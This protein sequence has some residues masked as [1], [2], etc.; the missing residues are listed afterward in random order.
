MKN[1]LISLL[2]YL[3]LCAILNAQYS[4]IYKGDYFEDT[5]TN[6]P[7]EGIFIALV[8]ANNN[9]TSWIGNEYWADKYRFKIS[10]QG[11]G[12]LKSSGGYNVTAQFNSD[13]G[14][15]LTLDKG[16]T[17]SVTNITKVSYPY[18]PGAASLQEDLIANP[19]FYS[20]NPLE[21]N[22]NGFEQGQISSNLEDQL[23]LL[24]GEWSAKFKV[25]VFDVSGSS[26]K[27]TVTGDLIIIPDSIYFYAKALGE[28]ALIRQDANTN[29]N[30]DIYLTG[31]AYDFD[32]RTLSASA[33]V[34]L[35]G[36]NGTVSYTI[37][38]V[39]SYFD[40]DK[41]G[42]SDYEEINTYSTNP[43]KADSDSDGMSDYA[44]I[45]AASNPNNQSEYPTYMKV[46]VALAKGI[47][48]GGDASVLIDGVSYPL[49]LV[50]GKGT[51]E[52]ALPTGS[53][54][55]VSAS[56]GALT[57]GTAKPV[58]MNKATSLSL[59]LDGDSDEDGLSD[60]QEAR[61]KGDPNNADTDGDGISDGDEVY[62]YRTSV[63]VADSD[64]DGFTD[65]Q[66][67]DLNTNPL[68]S[69]DKPEAYIER[70]VFVNWILTYEVMGDSISEDWDTA[71]V[72]YFLSLAAGDPQRNATI[73][74]KYSLDGSSLQWLI[75]NN[76]RDIDVTSLMRPITVSKPAQLEGE[77][78][79]SVTDDGS[80]Y[81]AEMFS[82]AISAGKTKSLSLVVSG[83]SSFLQVGPN[84]S[85]LDID[86]AISS[87]YKVLGL[88]KDLSMS[89]GPI[90][91]DGTLTMGNE[92]AN[93]LGQTIGPV[94]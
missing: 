23:S 74:L 14:I 72:A 85:G 50:R 83:E 13:G 79:S 12:S 56:L 5:P 28:S 34:A 81:A 55:S 35:S 63:N 59:I 77:V 48:G 41:D 47:S 40:T 60:S 7:D 93:V 6:G 46:K 51:L 57:S 86:L 33:N 38:Q 27:V 18:T 37:D 11:V 42:L 16:A 49:P 1:T 4:G 68:S 69:K 45:E 21:L 91:I 19:T 25:S 22:L 39:V 64:K 20:N 43:L 3:S 67:V 62:T 88:L 84:T 26:L 66:E 36:Y 87:D 61:Y 24:S 44:E 71:E 31:A 80:Y 52:V 82:L 92:V 32:N 89:D 30:A 70:P 2:I 90:L 17:A 65:K 29:S 76:S 73:H 53:T 10:D 78:S 8:D 9:V 94:N 15:S 54:Y 58:L 75:R